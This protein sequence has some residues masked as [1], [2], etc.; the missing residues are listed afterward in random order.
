M[1]AFFKTALSHNFFP[2]VTNLLQ[3]QF[4]IPQGDVLLHA[5]DFSMTGR[6]K[7][8]QQFQDWLDLQEFEHKI[9][10]AGNHDLTLDI[11]L[12]ETKKEG[13]LGNQYYS[14]HAKR[15]HGNVN[16][17]ALEI[18][19][20]FVKHCTY[21]EDEAVEIQGLKIYGSPHSPWF[22]DWAFG[23]ERGEQILEQWK[24]I[25]DDVDLLMTHGPPVGHGDLC[26]SQQR[27]GCVD[28]LMQIQHRIKPKVHVFGHIHE[29]QV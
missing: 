17:D 6:P 20:E 4:E 26:Q 12:S 11:D 7:E 29:G 5:G 24:K 8:I 19:K 2:A 18:K 13:E 16:Y 10:I 21:L 15:F 9:V 23:P 22:C 28:L 25:P 14:H 1:T 3:T 27:A